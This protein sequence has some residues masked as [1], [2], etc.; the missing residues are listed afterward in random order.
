MEGVETDEVLLEIGGKRGR[1]VESAEIIREEQI[2]KQCVT[3]DF[4]GWR[5]AI[6]AEEQDRRA[7]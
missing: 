3:S 4:S 7:Q 6:P 2:K 1:E 5:E